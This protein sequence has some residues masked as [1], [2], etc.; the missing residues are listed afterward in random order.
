ML[1]I[2]SLTGLFADSFREGLHELLLF[3]LYKNNMHC[4]YIIFLHKTGLDK[5]FSLSIDALF[6]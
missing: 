4:K 3:K 1:T 6:L 5:L 2:G